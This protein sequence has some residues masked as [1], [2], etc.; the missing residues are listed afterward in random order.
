[1]PQHPAAGPSPIESIHL[2]DRFERRKR[3]FAFTATSLPG[4]LIHLV[5]AGEIEQTCNGRRQ[6]LT[7][8][9]IVWYHED[10]WVEG[11]VLRAPWICFSVNFAAPTLSPPD[12][13]QRLLPGRSALE[14]AFVALQEAWR[15]P[16]SWRRDC[17]CQARLLALIAGIDPHD[18]E[19]PPATPAGKLWWEVESWARQ[20]IDHAS[21]V[22]PS[23]SSGMRG[24]SPEVLLVRR[25]RP[26]TLGNQAN[27]L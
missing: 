26:A 6:S 5:V 19:R 17:L 3:G 27:F 4:H 9:T 21:R 8:G 23:G 15:Q 11:R 12:F 13:S 20:R 7:P 22:A 2:V 18:S 16:P 14:P 1:M 25:A 10:E 24:Q